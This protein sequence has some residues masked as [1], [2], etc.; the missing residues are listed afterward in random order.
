MRNEKRENG[1]L[2]PECR[3]REAL[4]ACLQFQFRVLFLFVLF[5]FPI[6]PVFAALFN[7]R[8]NDPTWVLMASTCTLCER[9]PVQDTRDGVAEGKKKGGGLIRVDSALR[10]CSGKQYWMV[11]LVVVMIDEKYYVSTE[12]DYFTAVHFFV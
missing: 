9:V 4:R 2:P 12:T 7:L 11:V 10:Y 6:F 5:I 1:R 8:P 3:S